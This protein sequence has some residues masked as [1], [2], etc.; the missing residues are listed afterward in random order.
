MQFEK[1]SPTEDMNAEESHPDEKICLKPKFNQVS[2]M[3]GIISK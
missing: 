1:S 3:H 2:V